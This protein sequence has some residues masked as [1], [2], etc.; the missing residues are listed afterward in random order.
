MNRPIALA[1][2]IGPQRPRAGFTLL[3]LMV[4]VLLVGLAATLV[5]VRAAGATGATRLHSAAQLLQTGWQDAAR[6]AIHRRRPLLFEV[7]L[8]TS[9]YR[10]RDDARAN[11]PWRALPGARP[12]QVRV[13][14]TESALSAGVARLRLTP[15]G[16]ALPWALE[17]VAGSQRQV[18]YC[19]GITGAWRPVADW[20]SAEQ[21]LRAKCETAP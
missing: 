9:G 18:R 4:V 14:E 13:A 7:N 10:I 3:E 16:T 11:P 17:L 21:I 15:S 20:P 8:D 5:G 6:L 19:D 1:A 2:A 12:V